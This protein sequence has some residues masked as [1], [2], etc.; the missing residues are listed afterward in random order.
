MIL[1]EFMLDRMVAY[2]GETLKIVVKTLKRCYPQAFS[3]LPSTPSSPAGFLGLGV[4][5]MSQLVFL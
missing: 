3:T 2:V 1:A 4:F 5:I